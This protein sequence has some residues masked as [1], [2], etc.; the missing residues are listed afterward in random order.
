MGGWFCQD[1]IFVS[2]DQ[3]IDFCGCVSWVFCWG[4]GGLSVARKAENN[5]PRVWLR[6]PR[7]II[8]L[9]YET[10]A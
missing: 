5:I 10:N 4:V 9:A 7:N 2:V 6:N 1:C 8:L 3:I